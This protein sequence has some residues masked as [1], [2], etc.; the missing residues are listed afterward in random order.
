MKAGRRVY[1]LTDDWE[2]GNGLQAT[3]KALSE[4][5]VNLCHAR[6][7]EPWVQAQIL[8]RDHTRGHRHT[9]LELSGG[10]YGLVLWPEHLLQSVTIA[11]QTRMTLQC[12]YV[13]T[14]NKTA[15]W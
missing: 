3:D 15:A 5:R 13:D 7:Q 4:S 12:C 14:Y 10:F 9:P 1:H 2:S 6:P 8:F 11:L